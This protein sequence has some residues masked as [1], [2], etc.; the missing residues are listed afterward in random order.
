MALLLRISSANNGAQL[1][2]SSNIFD[3]LLPLM[4]FHTDTRRLSHDNETNRNGRWMF[5]RTLAFVVDLTVA[6]LMANVRTKEKIYQFAN[7][8]TELILT[9]LASPLDDLCTLHEIDTVLKIIYTLDASTDSNARSIDGQL[10]RMRHSS[11][12]LLAILS[13][14]DL[15]RHLLSQL[16]TT[17]ARQII[18]TT[19]W[20]IC[21]YVL[22]IAIRL[23]HQNSSE[24]TEFLP[25][26]L[27]LCEWIT[28]NTTNLSQAEK[29]S[30]FN[31][32]QM[33][34][35]RLS[36]PKMKQDLLMNMMKLMDSSSSLYNPH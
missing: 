3:A 29:S 31:F 22:A 20:R 14:D 13:R 35:D 8:L 28:L 32:C 16:E 2:V 5:G 4:D 27:K 26:I 19:Y 10:Q 12:K 34:I 21:F 1:L 23:V 33:P 18:S 17:R 30:L 6:S 24:L 11:L 7:H 15:F 25:G 36:T 9:I